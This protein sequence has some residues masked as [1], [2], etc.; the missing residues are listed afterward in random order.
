MFEPMIVHVAWLDSHV[1]GG[2][3]TTEEW[4]TMITA[5]RL[6]CE[7]VGWLLIDHEDYLVLAQTRGNRL[8]EESWADLV[9]IPRE[10]LLTIEQLGEKPP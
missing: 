5:G 4:Q 7:S 1:Y 10:A 2:W 6:R 8:S 3:H 9:Q